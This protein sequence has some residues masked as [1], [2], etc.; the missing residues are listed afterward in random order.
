M[1][2][3]NFF[4]QLKDLHSWHYDRCE[5]FKTIVDF[6]NWNFLMQTKP[7]EVYLHANIFK[8]KKIISTNIDQ[9]ENILMQSSGTSGTK[10][11]NIYSDRFTRIN[12]QRALIKIV[13]ENLKINVK[14]KLNYY[15]VAEEFSQKERIFDAQKAA[16]LGFS[17]FSNKKIFLLDKKGN[18]C[19]DKINIML[20]DSAPFIIFGFT[21][22]VYLKLLHYLQITAWGSLP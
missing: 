22:N 1:S 2:E 20:N 9:K 13:S 17:V 11:S 10:R 16:I 15:I 3:N 14:D 18:I 7:E 19:E 6:F 4:Q 12:Q 8:L 5:E 21:S